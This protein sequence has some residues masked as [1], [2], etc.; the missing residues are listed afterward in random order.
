MKSKLDSFSR[1]CIFG[2]QQCQK[3][4]EGRQGSI[5]GTSVIA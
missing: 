4:Q 3:G 5:E 2:Q 1:W